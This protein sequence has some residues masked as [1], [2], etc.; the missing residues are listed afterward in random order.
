[1]EATLAR[2]G[3]DKPKKPKPEKPPL[4]DAGPQ[5]REQHGDYVLEETMKAGVYR[6]RNR[7]PFALDAY[8]NRKLLGT[9]K[10]N[11]RRFEAGDKLRTDWTLAGLTPDVIGSYEQV[12]ASCDLSNWAV[13]RLDA[14][15]R[16]QRAVKAVGPIASDEVLGCCCLGLTIGRDRMVLLRRG[17]E[18]LAVHYGY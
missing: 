15:Q 16:W 13:T 9:G 14:Y 17:L 12:I 8:F 5:E 1:M 6:A 4:F 2:R 18:V 11:A 10:D 3:R 7:S